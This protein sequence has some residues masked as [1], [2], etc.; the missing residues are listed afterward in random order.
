MKNKTELVATLISEELLDLRVVAFRQMLNEAV[1]EGWEHAAKDGDV[2]LLQLMVDAFKDQNQRASFVAKLRSY[3]PIGR[4]QKSARRIGLDRHAMTSWERPK[5]WPDF[6]PSELQV[7]TT[8][9]AIQIG[10]VEL[11]GAELASLLADHVALNRRAITITEVDELLELLRSI[12]DRIASPAGLL[13]DTD[14]TTD[15]ISMKKPQ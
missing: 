9:N 6:S 7:S 11:S 1:R 2:H 12:R 8:A 15:L 4:S 14:S 5:T 3:L 13:A 10:S